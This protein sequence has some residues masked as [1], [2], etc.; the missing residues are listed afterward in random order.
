[1]TLGLLTLWLH[2]TLM[3]AAI[4][5]S[6]G[7]SIVLMLAYRAGDAGTLRGLA[8]ALTPLDRL[9]PIFYLGGG[10]FGLWTA[11]NFGYDLLAPWLVIAY[12]LFAV[13][14]ITGVTFNRTFGPRLVAATAD[15]PDGRLTPA[16]VE[17][18]ADPR[19]RFVTAL[20]TIVMV[21]L[22]FDMVIKPF[23]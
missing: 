14:M 13:A 23:S 12:V 9:I 1:M 18:F 10:L 8:R 17:M 11:I 22:I 16:I 5:I 2:I 6:F 3:F 21:A 7:P 20:D 15:I 19:Y 4:T